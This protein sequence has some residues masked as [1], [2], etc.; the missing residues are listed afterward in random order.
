MRIMPLPTKR[1]K[2]AKPLGQDE[3]A[4]LPG[5]PPLL[6]QLMVT[7]KISDAAAA[8]DY[9]QHRAADTDPF[10]MTGMAPPVE[11]LA[12]AIGTGERMAV[13]GDF[14]ADGV[15]ATSLLVEVLTTLGGQ[16]EP[17]I[18]D[19]VE[20]GY[21][22]HLEALRTLYRHKV[23]LV[24]TV[25]CGIRSVD[26]VERAS[27]GLDLIVTDHHRP[28]ERLPP[29]VAVINPKQPGCSYP[30]KELSGVGLAFKLAEALSTTVPGPSLPP[31]Y[32]DSLLDL[33]ALG[34]V[35]D[36]APLE[37]ENRS[38]V[39]RGLHCLNEAARLGVSALMSSAGLRRGEVDASA[40]GFRLG[41]RLNAA[42]RL[43]SA[44]LAYRLLTST[45]ALAT[46]DLVAELDALNRRRQQL[47]E[48]TVAAAE[49]Q[50]LAEQRDAHLY[51]ASSPDFLPGV[52][53]LAASRLTDMFYR[54][55]VVVTRGAEVSRGSCRS[56]PEFDIT[57]AL[58]ECRELLIRHGGHRAAAGFTVAT[59]NLETLRCRLQAIAAEQ[60]GEIERRPVL[61]ID[62]EVP[63]DELGW[64]IHALLAQ[65]QPCGEKNGTPVLASYGVPVRGLRL[66]GA[67]GRHLKL[68][69]GSQGGVAWEA[70]LFNGG[71]LAD[72]VPGVIDVAYCLQAK[73][74]N[75]EPRLQ[76]EVQDIRPAQ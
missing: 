1:W 12:R 60:L 59:A 13:Y 65:L 4:R 75:G 7:R 24:V 34:T 14:D 36:V 72:D 30:F 33:V 9:L 15:T 46:R 28:G 57:G 31:N 62:A 55:S 38:L 61:K 3:L 6:A 5:L 21:G 22:L 74:W 67:D 19:R 69:L 49:A 43:R 53:G 26:E 76:L 47:T 56:I 45:D 68:V 10:V 2:I 48:E 37:G 39:Q 29:A 58:D 73:E 71:P 44:M 35:A 54:P 23:R 18:P 27:R 70:M 25:D 41:P 17:Y 52:V 8:A 63:L 20:E 66:V 51:L 42:G 11:R 16:V 50:V 32:L 40:I 64:P